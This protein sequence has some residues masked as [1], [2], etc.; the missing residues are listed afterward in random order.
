MSKVGGDGARDY[1]RIRF[2]AGDTAAL[3]AREL[4]DGL[5]AMLGETID[6]SGDASTAGSE[7]RVE[8]GDTDK[9]SAKAVQ[10]DGDNIEVSREG[11]AVVMRAGSDRA[12]IHAAADL[13]EK[14]GAR[15]PVGAAPSYPRIEAVQIGAIEPYRVTPAFTRRAFVSDIM[16]W[17]YNFADRLELHLR[18]DRES[19][20]WMARRGINAFSY[21]RHAHD[22]RLRIDE[23]APMLSEYGIDAEYGGHVLQLLLPRDRF[24][25]NP[26]LFP[27]DDD[28]ARMARG[29]LCVSNRDAVKL[30]REGALSYVQAHRENRLLHIWGA[31]VWRGAWCRCGE[32]RELAPQLQYMEVVNEIANALAGD[33]SAPPVAYLAYHDTIEPHAGLKP[34][35]NVW[36]EWAPR[37][38]CYSHAIDDDACEINP[39][40]LESL[41][42]YI[43]IF[44]GR[45]HV[46]E[47]Y[48]DAILFGGLGFATPHV[49][50]RDLRAYRALGI[51][52]VSNLTFGAYSAMAYP[53]NLEA[54]VRG[55]IDPDFEPA[56]T[57]ADVAAG[58]HP[59]CA[60]EMATA[61]RAIERAS[62]LVLDY[63]DVMR[64]VMPAGK[65]A[66]KR[67]ELKTAALAFD[68]ALASAD[69][70]ARAIEH[71]RADAERDLWRYSA[72]VL[73]ALAEYL[74]AK[75]ETG[76]ERQ[77]RGE[78]AI[79]KIASAVERIRG[80]DLEIKGT[81]G[82]HDLEWI[83]EIWL[84]ALRRGLEENPPAAEEIF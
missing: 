74:G 40:Y 27:A 60:S 58:R 8:L 1:P 39:R 45:G 30:V 25:K 14:L 47:Y 43:E 54:F 62:K 51:T 82:A 65:A 57:I 84:N 37:E 7:L 64:P 33:A 70:I 77:R 50:A 79:E 17:N 46:F 59:G 52:S 18:H 5:A 68:E 4:A 2:G 16:T 21:I 31:D 53:V 29:N 73:N 12:L 55:S 71:P 10:L 13:L 3:A 66:R 83:R 11:G 80:I 56:H 22:T 63:G 72:D 36:F 35:K 38:R 42:R 48:A 20:P 28:G 34:L 26:E 81:W 49:I 23:I 19:I 41:K 6:A 32:C 75:L 24:E 78:I 15:F 69:R 44:D 61:Y 76:A 9:S 67:V